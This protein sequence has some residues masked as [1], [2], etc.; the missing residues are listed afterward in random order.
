MSGISIGISFIIIILVPVLF[1]VV[2]QGIRSKKDFIELKARL[3][4]LE[5]KIESK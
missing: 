4:K 2:V 1:Q 5:E 3:K